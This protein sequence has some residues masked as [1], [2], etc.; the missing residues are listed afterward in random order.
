M[1][2]INL[3]AAASVIAIAALGAAP[4]LAAGTSAGSNIVNNVTVNYQVGAVAQTAINA[5]NSLVVDRKISLTVTE[6]GNA[7]TT[8]VPGQTGAVTSFLVTNTSNATLDLGLALVQPAGGTTAHGGTDNFDVTGASLFVDTNG[9]GTYEAGTDTAVTYLDEIA[10]D[11]SRTVFVVSSIPAGRV[12]GDVAGVTLTATAFNAGTI[13][14]QG[15]IVTNDSGTANTAGMDTVFADAAGAT[16]AAADG[17]F[18]ARDDFTVSTAT[19][20]VAKV[21]KIISD[22]INGTT[23]P[24]MIPGAT[25]EYCIQ[26]AN[27]AGGATATSVAISDP[28]PA[29]TTYDAGY[30]IFLNG[31]VTGGVCNTD[32]TAGGSQ[33]AG[34]VSGTLPTVTAGQTRTLYF[35]VTIN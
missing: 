20:S 6:P 3:L 19:L 23:N 2:T 17:K 30:G 35:R 18:S 25:V 29:Q 7:T 13:G 9:N 11:T 34:T 16:D 8:V 24:K 5:S 12:N 4:A 10:A 31:T 22:P 14:T 15:T 28:L 33:A 32:G 21:S 27:A 26:V 1:K